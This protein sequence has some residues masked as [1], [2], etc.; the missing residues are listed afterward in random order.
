MPL[1]IAQIPF[2]SDLPIV[3][4]TDVHNDLTSVK[5]LVQKY[6]GHQL[7]CLGDIVDLFK[8]DSPENRET[9]TYFYEEGIPTLK[10]NH[11]EY[12]ACE[13]NR[14]GEAFP[15]N[16]LRK[17]IHPYD[18]DPA[19]GPWLQELPDGFMIDLDDGKTVR[20][21]HNRPNCKWS[22]TPATTLPADLIKIYDLTQ[23]HSKVIIG[24]QHKTQR[25]LI[26]GPPKCEFHTL[27]SLKETQEYGL[28]SR[29]G[30]FAVS[31]LK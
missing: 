17:N 30:L 10:G 8:P 7:I 26:L 24:H 11:E 16:V 31:V 15:V 4:I 12:I 27:G 19:T 9:I 2:K 13:L 14:S 20:C 29:N 23:K 5:K 28:L 21:Y 1:N 6:P 25:C 22:F 18:L 3:I